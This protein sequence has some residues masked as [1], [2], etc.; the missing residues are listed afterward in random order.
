MRLQKRLATGLMMELTGV[1]CSVEPESAPPPPPPGQPAL[2]T[3]KSQDAVPPG[4]AEPTEPG[5]TLTTASGLKYRSRFPRFTPLDGRNQA[6]PSKWQLVRRGPAAEER[7]KLLRAGLR[8]K[9]AH[10][11]ALASWSTGAT[12]DFRNAWI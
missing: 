8:G 1:G 10:S 2:V 4:I 11:E 3:A 6:A 7:G 9:A 5:E 12:S